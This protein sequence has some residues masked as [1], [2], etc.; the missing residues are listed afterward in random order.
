M[1]E[2]RDNERQFIEELAGIWQK[3]MYGTAM[4][5]GGKKMTPWRL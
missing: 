2:N 3:P 1:T 4:V 5:S